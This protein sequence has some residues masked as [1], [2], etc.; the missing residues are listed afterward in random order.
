[1]TPPNCLRHLKVPPKVH[2]KYK[3]SIMN[4]SVFSITEQ[5]GKNPQ[6]H[7]CY[8][9]NESWSFFQPRFWQLRC[10]VSKQPIFQMIKGKFLN[11]SL[12]SWKEQLFFLILPI[13]HMLLCKQQWSVLQV[14]PGCRGTSHRLRLA[15][16]CAGKTPIPTHWLP[17]ELLAAHSSESLNFSKL[18]TMH[19]NTLEIPYSLSPELFFQ[20]NYTEE[21]WWWWCL[22]LFKCQSCSILKTKPSFLWASTSEKRRSPSGL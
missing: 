9:P 13:V 17:A 5:E 14:W 10:A 11:N 8:T 7:T 3:F 2:M 16:G 19:I 4:D 20:D 22:F 15:R 21:L 18:L 12:L 6:T 1:M